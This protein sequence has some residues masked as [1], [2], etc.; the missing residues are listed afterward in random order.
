MFKD[1][2]IGMHGSKYTVKLTLM[3]YKDCCVM[4]KE[5]TMSCQRCRYSI[6]KFLLYTLHNLA[7]FLFSY[8]VEPW[9]CT[10]KITFWSIF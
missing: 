3:L 10:V 5:L 4:Y 8:N 1:I 9:T 2:W 7:Q 6:A